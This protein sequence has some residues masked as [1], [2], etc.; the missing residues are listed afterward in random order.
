MENFQAR[1]L[2]WK[3]RS[4][5]LPLSLPSEMKNV[6]KT[7]SRGKR[8]SCLAS[9]AGLNRLISNCEFFST[10][11][12]TSLQIH[13]NPFKF[14]VIISGLARNFKIKTKFI[15]LR[16][17]WEGPIFQKRFQKDFKKFM[18]LGCRRWRLRFLKNI[19]KFSKNFPWS[20]ILHFLL[21]FSYLYYTSA[22][23]PGSPNASPLIHRWL[24]W[25]KTL[26]RK[27]C[28]CHSF[29]FSIPY[30]SKSMEAILF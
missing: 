9:R 21:F 6:S 7:K 20:A 10:P 29:I 28:K 22:E 30:Y 25:N 17:S 24:S 13:E 12:L 27:I 26:C 11:L 16:G 8:L 15:Y 18:G 3:I 19:C 2:S 23:V 1:I 5:N 14:Y 4:G